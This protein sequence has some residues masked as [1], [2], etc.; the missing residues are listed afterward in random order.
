MSSLT[1]SFIV[2]ACVSCGALA[3]MALHRA[4]PEH[5]L[6]PESREVI[7]LGMGL[8]ATMTALVLGL[9]VAS[10]KTSYDNQSSELTDLSAKVV[11]FDRALAHYGPETQEARG[12]LRAIV[13]R[14]IDQTWPAEGSHS[15]QI[16]AAPGG[17]AEALYDAVQ[18]LSP[19]NDAQRALQAQALSL[20]V[21]LGHTRWLMA[22]QG[23]NPMPTA[24][25]VVVVLWLV[26]MF[27]GFGLFAPRNTTV[28]IT[29]LLCA[30]SVSAAI[31]LILELYRPFQGVIQISSAPLRFALA[32]LGQ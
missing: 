9:L 28:V 11:L 10:A 12:L 17:P 14:V 31:F 5:H 32:H 18:G 24:F 16:P 1:I 25:L 20:M 15:R 27:A 13:Q 2:F 7:K 22:E 6:S 29:L 30:L 26:V 3:G 19:K 21:D 23:K 8:I 4:L